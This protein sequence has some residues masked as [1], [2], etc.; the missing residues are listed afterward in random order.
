MEPGEGAQAEAV[1]GVDQHV[2]DV[3]YVGGQDSVVVVAQRF[4]GFVHLAQGSDE[5]AIAQF[6]QA[7]YLV[8]LG[9]AVGA[10]L[11]GLDDGDETVVVRV[12]GLAQVAVV[13]GQDR[14]GFPQELLVAGHAVHPRHGVGDDGRLDGGAEVGPGH[15]HDVAG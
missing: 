6:L 1:D 13:A 4:V 12:A 7:Q 2:L 5:S 15:A 3:E 8:V 9:R 11:F 14:Q 10:R